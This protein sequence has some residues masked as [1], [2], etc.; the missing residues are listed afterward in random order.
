MSALNAMPTSP[1]KPEGIRMNTSDDWRKTVRVNKLIG[2]WAAEKLGMK[3][4]DA[5]VYSDGL[6]LDA[7]D[8]ARSDVLSKIR[9]DFDA[10]GVV[11]SDEQILDVMNELRL[12]VGGQMP[13]TRK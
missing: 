3:D 6:A 1:G 12:E 7:L 2:V 4:R 5:D 11:Q 13:G 10:A 8:P 9:K